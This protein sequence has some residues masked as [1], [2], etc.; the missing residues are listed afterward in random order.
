MKLPD[1]PG[2]PWAI[3]T[4]LPRP[5][6]ADDLECDVAV[7]GAG[8]V[9]LTTA[10]LAVR[11]GLSVAVL[12]AR[13][14]GTGTSGRTTA[15]ASALQ[16]LRYQTIAEHHG[17]EAARS[18]ARAQLDG[19]RWMSDHVADR[20]VDCRWDERPSFTHATTV[21][22]RQS[23]EAELEAATAAGLDVSMA[24][25]GLPFVT[26]GAV[27]LDGQAQL[28]PVAYLAS[29]AAEVVS[30][31]EGRLF[32]HTRVTGV[33]GHRR[34]TV[35]APGG[36]VTADHVVVATLLPIV[37]RGL[38]FAR[39]EPMSSYLVAM[40]C[41]GE[42]VGGMYLGI[43]EP[44][45]SLRTARDEEGDLLLVGGEG[46]DTGRGS[47]TTP[48]YRALA[49][50]ASEHF[51]V[52]PVVARWSAHDYVPSDQLPWVGP[53]SAVTPRVLV[54]TGFQKWGMTMGTAAALALADRCAGV[55]DGLSAPWSGLFDPHRVTLRG[56]ATAARINAE[57]AGRM[58]SGWIRP[59]T[60]RDEKGAVTRR[61]RG[62][63]PV[64]ATGAEE[65]VTVVCTHLGGVCS[66]NDGDRTWDCPLH[67]SRFDESG[68]VV[69]GPATT[70][71]RRRGDADD[72]P[73]GAA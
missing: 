37:D 19:L 28:D 38:F 55:E 46:H 63:V 12:E 58:A 9:G 65:D 69:A 31:P 24:D 4:T 44:S 6:L 29:L 45:R 25:P 50:W 5:P 60:E 22:G 56:T 59:G 26:T 73:D 21:D 1:R 8:I 11:A 15:K 17:R 35:V 39:A 51:D 72:G 54:A 27:R 71:L 3:P 64:S 16:G 7:V 49:D 66:W 42:P 32:E 68:E 43:D 62:I 30:A 47:P 53:S 36:T 41:A 70:P 61:R 18:Y 13:T 67:G 33:R 2:T 20:A 10:V 14:V 40:R 48:R 57:V 34:H 52:G 23:L